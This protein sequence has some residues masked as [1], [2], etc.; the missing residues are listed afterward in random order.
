MTAM[1][2]ATKLTYDDY[3]VI[4]DDGRRHE[5]VD[6]EHYV[7]PAPNI[8]HQ[9]TSSNLNDDLRRHVKRRALGVVLYAP[10]DVLLSAENVVQPDLLFVS[11]EH[12][13]RIKD[14]NIVG[15][16]DLVVEI[17]SN[18]NKRYDEVVKRQL[19]E[20]F[21]VAEYWIVDPDARTVT[22]LRLNGAN[23]ET[24]AKLSG[25]DVLTSPLFPDFAIS[26]ATIFP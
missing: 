8:A 3:L 26:V 23:Y 15:A 11:T 9:L 7:V 22:V 21:G 6:G 5:I 16:P 4:P 2:T 14:G 18:S 24:V 10:V 20:R 12:R 13:A 19:Y 1:A 17:L 25:D